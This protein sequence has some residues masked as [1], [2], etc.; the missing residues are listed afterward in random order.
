MKNVDFKIII[1][2]FS[3][4]IDFLWDSL[5]SRE[6]WKSYWSHLRPDVPIGIV[7]I[8]LCGWVLSFLVS[9]PYWQ[10][11]LYAGVVIS[12]FGLFRAAKNKQELWFPFAIVSATFLTLVPFDVCV[13]GIGAVLSFGLKGIFVGPIWLAIDLS[14]MAFQYHKGQ[15]RDIAETPWRTRI[16]ILIIVALSG[17]TA[18][19]F[20]HAIFTFIDFF[21]GS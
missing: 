12:I 9:I 1:E 13:N 20:G 11:L 4:I 18:C 2:A 6:T 7:L 3:R 21:T 8:I 10:G 19:I 17:M 5:T 15:I 16:I 14:V